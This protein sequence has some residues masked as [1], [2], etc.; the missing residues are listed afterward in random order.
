MFELGVITK[1]GNTLICELDINRTRFG[2]QPHFRNITKR[3]L[4][5]RKIFE[6]NQKLEKANAQLISLLEELKKTQLQLF[7][8]EK[9]A[10]IGQLAAGIAHEINNPV[11][12]ISCNLEQCKI[13]LQL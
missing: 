7:Q 1:D 2:I 3:K 11:G 6:E 4:L 8:S 9:M 5:E 10:S 13:I 12:Y